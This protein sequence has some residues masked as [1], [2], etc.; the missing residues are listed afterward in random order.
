[1]QSQDPLD[2]GWTYDWQA[3]R[4]TLVGAGT[5]ATYTA[6]A[7]L[8]PGYDTVTLTISAGGAPVSTHYCVLFVYKQFIVLKADD[9]TNY[10]SV[11]ANWRYYLEQVVDTRH[12]KTSVGIIGRFMDPA[13][14]NASTY[15]Q[16]VQYTISRIAGGYV[17]F[18]CHGYDHSSGTGW[19]EFSGSTYDFQQA[20]LDLCQSLAQ[21]VLGIRFTAFGAPFNI[22]DASTT[23]LINASPDFSCWFFGPST[24]SN[25][26]VF[27]RAGEIE[28]ST[29]V[30]SYS[31]FLA[32]YG[33]TRQVVVLQHHPYVQ[34]FRDGFVE[35][36]QILDYLVAQKVTFVQPTEYQRLIQEGVLPIDPQADSDTNGIPDKVEGVGDADGDGLP[37]FLDPDTDGDGIADLVEGTGDVDA[38]TVPNFLDLDSNGNGISDAEEGTGDDDGDGIPNFLDRPG[39]PVDPQSFSVVADKHLLRAGQMAS[40]HLSPPEGLSPLWTYQWSAT[41]GA[42]AV[43]GTTATLTLPSLVEPGAATVTVTVRQNGAVVGEKSATFWLYNQ[44]IILK[45]DD[46]QRAYWI[47]GGVTTNWV[48]YVNYLQGKHIKSSMGVITNSLD[49]AF[50]PPSEWD[51]PSNEFTPFVAYMKSLNAAGLFEFFHHGYDHLEGGNWTEF[52]QTDYAYQ[53]YHLDTG[54]SLARQ[55]LGFPLTTFAAPFNWIDATTTQVVNESQDIN[56]W[57]YGLS[58]S[59]KMILSDQGVDMIEPVTTGVPDYTRFV[60]R[61]TDAGSPEYLVLQHHPD[62]DSFA[63][64]FDK[65]DQIIAF[66]QGN[67][68]TFV[69]PSEYYKAATAGAFPLAPDSDSDADGIPD[70]TDGQTDPDNDGLYNFL[71]T[72]SDGDGIPDSGEGTADSN[73]NGVPDFLEADYKPAITA[74]P[75][76]GNA[77]PGQPFTFSITATGSE[78][79]YFQWYKDSNAIHGALQSSFTI[80]SAQASDA[81]S[82]TCLVTNRAGDWLGN[83]LSNPAVLTVG[84]A[85]PDITKPVITLVGDASVNV[86]VGLPYTDAGATASDDRDGVITANIVVTGSVNTAALGDYTLTYNVSDAAGNPADAV[87][88]TVHVVADGTKPV[89]TLLGAADATIEAGSAYTDAGATAQDNHDGDITSSIAVTG[90]VNTASV[91][92]YTLTFNASDAAGNPADP[93]VRT[94]HVVDTTKPVITLLGLPEANSEVGTPYTDAGATAA[95][96]YD[97]NISASIV[98]T[99]SINTATVGTYTLT[100]NVSDAAGNPADPV[101]RTVHV[102]DTTKP[103][104]TRIGSPTIIVYF[105]AAYTDAGA[106]ASDNYDGNI[107]SNIAVTGSVNTAVVGTYTLTYDVS[108]AAGNA[109]VPVTRTVQ[110]VDTVKPV[111]TLLGSKSVSIQGGSTYTDAGATALDNYDGNI[112]SKI[113]VT[114]TVNTKVIGTYTVTYNVSDSSGNAATPVVRKVTVVD[115][116]KPVITRLGTSPVKVN[117]FSTYVDAGATA[118]D[119]L[120]GN[121]TSKIVVTG[122]VNTSKL[123]TYYIYYNVKDTAGNV[124]K[125]VIRTVQVVDTVK[126]VIAVIGASTIYVKVNSLYVDPGATAS[127]NYDGDITW[128][129]V[130]T[131]RVNIFVVGSY[132]V[133]YNV[134]DSS[135]NAAYA[136]GRTV[137]VVR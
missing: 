108:D 52:Y 33:P 11:D 80:P 102:V 103:V 131:N 42:L 54:S 63:R 111:I 106:T 86:E 120:D 35:F 114:N 36:N 29:G 70:A 23:T 122:T 51:G 48:N 74:Q 128:K 59:T 20:H 109:A 116:T 53:K 84:P 123:G 66:L 110:V 58:G 6:G 39:F 31:R 44:F 107:T 130:V 62:F 41:Q 112:T 5:S 18:W 117:V 26:L 8:E 88:R 81:G 28:S 3:Q 113:V 1:V 4:G 124:A 119:N 73:G 25:K 115:T 40:L 137:N 99:G 78:P 61:Y 118:Y 13:W 37:N 98:V 16:D 68:V 55:A 101:T 21:S 121:I 19:Y 49:P 132:R 30:P 96:S 34:T 100:F 92:T 72:D 27:V 45:A 85:G 79:L 82:Y 94:V 83:A 97:G 127:D 95:D 12:L 7:G 32:T 91:G 89:I 126:P 65:F 47:T 17:E 9:W 125:T 46:W 105:G 50:P 67:K 43:S 90:S 76:G 135:G 2:P 136:V 64:N 69:K 87:T 104:I 133:T 60:Q 15:A 57:L 56:L 71:D 129:I 38:D 22:T 24:G 93:V 14:N 75:L 10:K 77:E 134:K